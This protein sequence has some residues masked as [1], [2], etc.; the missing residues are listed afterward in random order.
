ML[1]AAKGNNPEPHFHSAYE[2]LKKS[3]KHYPPSSDIR[4]FRRCWHEQKESIKKLFLSGSYHLDLQK[5]IRLSIAETNA[6]WSSPDALILKVLTI[7]IQKW[8]NPSFSK[9]CYHLKGHGGLKG[10]LKNFRG[11]SFLNLAQKFF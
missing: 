11:R 8:L 5:R 2:W 10:T 3:W 7:L 4:D 1:K 6:L 9:G